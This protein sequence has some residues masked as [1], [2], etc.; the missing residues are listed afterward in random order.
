[1]S[2]DTITK[3][4]AKIAFPKAE[5]EG[6][7][8]EVL[9]ESARS[10][11]SL[12]GIQFPV[13]S[14]GQAAASAHLDSLDVVSLLCDVEP[15]LGFELKDSLVRAGGYNSV[16]QAIGHLMPRIETAWEKNGNKGAK[17]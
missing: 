9:L 14:A 2:I 15:I 12:R 13:E 7:L 8:Q 11:A 5:V 16:N 17:Q 1:M 6:K 3:P 10:Y 4:N